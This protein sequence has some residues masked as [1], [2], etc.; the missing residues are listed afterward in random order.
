MG[1]SRV[2]VTEGSGAKKVGTYSVTEDGVTKEIQRIARN[3]SDGTEIVE[4]YNIKITEVGSVTYIAKAATGTSQASALWQV[5][6]ID[7]TTGTVIT[8][9]DGNGNF[10]N[11]ATDLTVLSYS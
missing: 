6:K 1:N 8:W 7:E 5:Q 11:V 2:D 4:E 3:R 9:A 10:D